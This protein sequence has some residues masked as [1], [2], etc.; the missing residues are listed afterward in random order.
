[1]QR[2]SKA[3]AAPLYFV[4]IRVITLIAGVAFA[5]RREAF[6]APLPFCLLALRHAAAA[7]L[8]LRRFRRRLHI[9][10]YVR[11]R[12]ASHFAAAT[13]PR[14]FFAIFEGLFSAAD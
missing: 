10:L 7:A 6:R 5:L 2:V 12:H 8:R 13:M 1:M 3:R 14:F 9:S 11:V 4:T